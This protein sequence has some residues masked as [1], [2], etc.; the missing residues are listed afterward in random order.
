MKKLKDTINKQNS[1]T[2]TDTNKT[3]QLVKPK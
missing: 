2:T 1:A 3:K